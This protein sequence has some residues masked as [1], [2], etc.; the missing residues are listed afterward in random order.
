L[1]HGL[2]TFVLAA[3]CVGQA[4]AADLNQEYRIERLGQGAALFQTGEESTT[5]TVVL[6]SRQG[7]VVV[8]TGALPSRAA[9]LRAAIE[10]EF[11][12][13]DFAYV[14]NTHSH[15]DHTDGNQ[16][17]A[18]VPIIA[19]QNAPREMGEWSRSPQAIDAFLE[20]R[21]QWR[22]M[23]EAQ[24]KT[25]VAGSRDEA[26]IHEEMAENDALADDLRSGR[27]TPTPPGV[28]FND[29]LTLDLGDL[30]ADLIS[31][32]PDH[33][34][35]D[36]VVH[37]PQFGLLLVGDL[38]ARESLPCFEDA[39]NQVPHWFQVLDG[40]LNARW[41][42]VERVVCGHGE[43]MT[44]DEFRT[45]VAYLRDIWDGVAAARQEGATLAATRERFPFAEK[46]PALSALLGE[47]ADPDQHRANIESA[48]RL[49]S[50]SSAQA[51]DSLISARGPEAAVAEYRATIAGNERY[52]AIES[53]LIALGYRHLQG[54]KV[55]EAT[56]VF[57]IATEAFPEAW[58]AWDS[59]GEAYRRSG[60]RPQADVCYAKSVALNPGNTGG[61]EMLAETKQPLRFQPGA[62]TG[63]EGP[64]LG[65][66]PPGKTP[67][68]FAPGIV[69]SSGSF[70][71]AITFAPDG[72]E[73]FFT[74]RPDG[75]T[76]VLMTARWEKDGWTA[77]EE[78]PIAKGFA[79]NEPH[80]T[81]DGRKLF[82]GSRRPQ[83]GQTSPGSGIWVVERTADGGWGEARFH[84]P[85]M[86]VSSARNGSLYM[87]DVTAVLGGGTI[88]YPWIDG[89][90][91][92]PQKLGGGVN[93][94]RWADHAFIAPDES[95][96][97]FD[98]SDRPGGQGGEGDLY[99]CFKK[100]DGSWS[101][102]QNLG[103]T[104]NTPG[105]NFCPS[106]SPDGK[107][108]FYMTNRDIYWVSAR[109]LDPL[110]AK[111]LG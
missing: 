111:A 15:Y 1:R 60:D 69:S 56:A 96:I 41:P 64:C 23:L 74:G 18:D 71:F 28:L 39:A 66:K 81:P 73:L 31:F 26:R 21:A 11:G 87:T 91:G 25:A 24:L 59:L 62:K 30:S 107:Y 70:D 51:L 82:F 20:S 108:I 52:V 101:T 88:V 5:N 53:D 94:P 27:F 8:D 68:V 93:E 10:Q 75:A 65:Q 2:V 38:F 34:E 98:S 79:S 97:L 106:V 33:T 43:V 103:N 92:P 72:R 78:S 89:K 13:T 99:V 85:G 57:Q 16:A 54:G 102:A 109:I 14:I 17:F 55:A 12:R 7:L 40:L 83:P 37:V 63:L 46:F 22:T 44:V 76:N 110:R 95:Y 86:Y 36:I 77:P 84:G 48:W 90:Y 105:T 67:K 104:I 6:A 100:P 35:S 49:Q 9:A 80:V 45:Q 50:D 42:T 32:G 4:R 29:R 3:V 47:R 58:N 19:H 61:R